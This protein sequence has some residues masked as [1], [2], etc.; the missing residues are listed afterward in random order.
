MPAGERNI[1]EFD[2]H[3]VKNAW[4]L[5]GTLSGMLLAWWVDE[6]HTH[7]ETKAVWWAQILK[8]LIGVA[9]VMGTRLALKPLFAA[10]F[11]DH[12]WTSGL[13]YFMM[14]VVGGVLWPMTF[15]FWGKLG[16]QK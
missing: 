12:A 2:A 6:R 7:F 15:G 10:I 4:T 14:A 13:R 9:L 5:L 11:G 8:L 3:G 16:T 1:A